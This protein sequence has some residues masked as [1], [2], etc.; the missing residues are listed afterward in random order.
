MVWIVFG[1]NYGYR[2]QKAWIHTY[3]DCPVFVSVRFH[4][5]C[6][7]SRWSNCYF[8]TSDHEVPDS[9]P[10][11]GR[12]PGLRIM[13]SWIR[14]PLEAEFPDFG[15]WA[16]IRIPLEAE[17]PDFRSWGPGFESRW[18]QNSPTRSWGPGFESCW[19]SNSCHDYTGILFITL[20][21]SQYVLNKSWRDVKHK[22]IGIHRP[23]FRHV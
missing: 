8:P 16:R 18:R 12:I 13:R 19:R 6:E 15:S 23:C 9:N 20:S 5:T 2:D 21:S 11:G 10:A 22:I 3:I 14:I 17:F 7:V 4:R 1:Y